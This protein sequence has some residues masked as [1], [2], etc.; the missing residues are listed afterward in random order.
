MKRSPLYRLTVCDHRIAIRPGSPI[1]HSHEAAWELARRLVPKSGP[2]V[3]CGK[4]QQP[5]H[6]AKYWGTVTRSQELR[7]ADGGV[8]EE[9]QLAEAL[10]W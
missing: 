8:F 7:E 4:C 6:I 5:R 3:T 2:G 10:R 9:A 1:E